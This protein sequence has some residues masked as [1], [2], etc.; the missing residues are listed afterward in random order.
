MIY[1]SEFEGFIV[2]VFDLEFFI[3]VTAVIFVVS[4]SLLVYCLLNGFIKDLQN[5][6]FHV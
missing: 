4:P 1:E 5:F 2:G 6:V 3:S